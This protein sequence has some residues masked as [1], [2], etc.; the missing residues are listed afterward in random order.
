MN[1]FFFCS[2]LFLFNPFFFAILFTFFKVPPIGNRAKFPFKTST[3]VVLKPGTSTWEGIPTENDSE[4]DGVAGSGGGKSGKS[5]RETHSSESEGDDSSDDGGG[6]GG[7][8]SSLVARRTARVT[9]SYTVE[10][11]SATSNNDQVCYGDSGT[12]DS[13]DERE[14]ER[15]GAHTIGSICM[16]TYFF[17]FFSLSFFV[18]FF[19]VFCCFFW[20]SVLLID[21][22]TGM[23]INSSVSYKSG[24]LGTR[25]LH[26]SGECSIIMR[27]IKGRDGDPIW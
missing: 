6:G 15:R 5:D 22:S 26:E 16:L 21:V 9:R 3:F 20:I 4:K 17:L 10:D 2:T 24:Y 12:C 7:G 19:V 23:S 25:L 11:M 27:R 13:E 1:F 14:R 18:L 8:G